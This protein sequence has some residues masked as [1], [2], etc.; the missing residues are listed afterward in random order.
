[1][2][3]TMDYFDGSTKNIKIIEIYNGEIDTCFQI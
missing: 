1:M 2:K 3:I